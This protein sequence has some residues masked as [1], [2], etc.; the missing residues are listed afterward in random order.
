MSRRP[1]SLPDA[2][3][4]NVSDG[5]G[6]VFN[7]R[8]LPRLNWYGAKRAISYVLSVA[9]INSLLHAF[10]S[11]FLSQ[12]IRERL[13]LNRRHTPYKLQSGSYVT[14]ANTL[15]DVVAKDIYWGNGHPKSAAVWRALRL[16][17]ILGTMSGTFLDVGSYSGVFAL[18]SARANP[19]ISAVA[20]EIVPENFFL[21]IR[22]T[23]END[24]IAN[25]T[26]LLLGVG[27]HQT[28]FR[29]PISL[30]LASYA[31]SISLLSE[32]ESGVEVPVSTLDVLTSGRSGPFAMKI[33]VEGFEASVFEGGRGF[34]QRE[35]P[36]IICELLFGAKRIEE[37]FSF[38]NS[39]EYRFFLITD[40][41]FSQR[42][43]LFPDIE[44]RDWLFSPRSDIEE[45][46]KQVD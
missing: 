34:I 19:N 7:E 27:S 29:V 21:L 2:S 33:D 42:S 14:L 45:V 38:L 37:I 30:G 28:S 18:V 24:L 41:G 4:N 36:D 44:F 3:E 23:V 5:S 17:E 40:E 8:D 10:G 39:L 15:N 11:V 6:F 25:V 26:P 12:S 43:E 46:L 16:T 20:F 13:P 9:A 31:S 32:F 35:K 1:L 22:N